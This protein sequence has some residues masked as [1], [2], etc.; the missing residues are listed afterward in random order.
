MVSG[1]LY[2][3]Y[4]LSLVSSLCEEGRL[5]IR[6][7]R[8]YLWSVHGLELSEGAIVDIVHRVGV[9]AREA[10]GEVLDRIRASPVVGADEAGWRHHGVNGYVWTFNT[11]TD[12]YF[13]RGSRRK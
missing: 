13:V 2:S 6:M 10:L 7:I 9:R 4:V 3:L 8:W 1:L 5:P 11:P 12:R